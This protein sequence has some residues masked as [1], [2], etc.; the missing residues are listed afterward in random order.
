[1]SIV[2]PSE[3]ARELRVHGVRDV[4]NAVRRRAEY[5]SDA[6]NYRIRPVVVVYPHNADEVRGALDVARSYEVAVTS[7][8]GGTSTAGNAVGTGI[9]LDFSRHMGKVIQINAADGTATVQPGAILDAITAAA[10]PYGLRFG[11]D[12]ST[13]SRATIG[14]SIGNNACGARALRYGRLADNVVTLRSVL[15]DG[16]E[17]VAGTN[18]GSLSGDQPLGRALADFVDRRGATIRTEFGRFKR[19][20]SGYSLEHLLPE[21]GSNLAKLLTGSEGT[22]AVTVEA[23][24]RLVTPPLYTAL[25]VCA[26]RTIADAADDV[27]SILPYSP[28]A[29]EGIDEVLVRMAQQRPRN[30]GSAALPAGGAWLL[31]EFGADTE[32]AAMEAAAAAAAGSAARDAVVLVG[33]DAQALWRL[34]EDGAGLAGRT[35]SG[36]PAWP[37]WEDAA[38]PPQNL[39]AYLR[40]FTSLMS[41]HNLD[42]IVYGH[43]GDGCVHARLDFPLADA[44]GRYRAFVEEA[45]DLVTKHGGSLSGEHG[46]GRARG[47]LLGRMYSGQALTALTELKTLFD[48]GNV[49][50]PGV[51]VSPDRLDDNLRLART[52]PVVPQGG[53]S[54]PEDAGDLSAAVHRCTG[55]GKC[56]S[57]STG[58]AAV[59]CPSYIATRDEKD[60]TRGRARVLQEA[61][62][63]GFDDG[64]RSDEVTEALDLCLACKGCLSDCPT[65]VDMATYKAESL[66]ARFR[67]RIRPRSHYALGWLP[68]WLR[69][70]G[71]VPGLG[72][73]LTARPA[74]ANLAKWLAGVDARRSLPTLAMKSFHRALDGRSQEPSINQPPRG[75]VLLW[76]DSFVNSL[77]PDVGLAAVKVLEQAGYSVTCLEQQACCGLTWIS[78]GQLEGARR[79]L[80]RTLR[81]LEPALLA[82]IPIVVL[83]PSCLAVY[84]KDA[85]EL[86][87]NDDRALKLS[88][89][90]RTLAELLSETPGWTPPD[91]RGTDVIV[92]VHCHQ[93]AV[94][95]W[96]ADEAL[97]TRAGATIS[98]VDGCCGLAGNFGMER[99]HYEVSV[100]VAEANLLPAIRAARD[101]TMIL[102]DGFSC[103][104]QVSDLTSTRARHLAEILASRLQ[105]AAG[106]R[107]ES[108]TG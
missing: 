100:A 52:F 2:K 19:Q 94:S 37:G 6:S 46:D 71:L 24:V 43:F 40:E 81:L 20:V 105:A 23:T 68:R 80:H 25:A 59:M 36:K 30:L 97:L 27:H 34:R 75:D 86:L 53:F 57:H 107:S 8:G 51:L 106:R 91:L 76:V 55:V 64:L 38:V 66:H 44:P 33:R 103:R 16:T 12:P 26:Y 82:G 5:S 61:L 48:P 98:R 22:L 104:T 15:A 78:T 83:E 11:P 60:S 13:H 74:G 67:G 96:A 62:T 102:A 32:A 89:A 42:G 3:L 77:D 56:R 63:G 49:L 84:R 39:G 90:A 29:L 101:S 72:N 70:A 88:R 65:S 4:D 9:V 99:G 1:M 17:L 45:A 54:Y 10:A 18:L 73:F 14:G 93:H 69:L 28:V 21:N 58:H 92:Q 35:A 41:S 7:R 85:L 31:A 108:Q 87:P 79:Q 95:G 50:N 47:E